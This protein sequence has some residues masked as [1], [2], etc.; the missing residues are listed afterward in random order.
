MPLNIPEGAWAPDAP[1]VYKGTLTRV[2][3]NTSGGFQ[4]QGYRKWYFAVE[5]PAAGDKPAS[6]E[7]VSKLTSRNLGAG[8]KAFELLSG[9]LGEA[10]KAGQMEE[11]IGRQVLLDIGRNSKGFADVQG[12]RP[13]VDPQQTLDGVPR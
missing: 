9:I 2:E 13:F 11:P 12:V 4:G 3:E 7:E 1:G 8:S 5:V 10:P 6:I